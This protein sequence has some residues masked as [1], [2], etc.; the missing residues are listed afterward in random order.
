MDNEDLCKP[1]NIIQSFKIL[2]GNTRT[3][4]IF[5]PL[6][7][8]P[9]VL[10]NFYLSLYMKE[11]G[12]TD[13]QIGY[14]ISIGFISGTFFSLIA[15][16][17]T[18]KLGRKKT[19]LI[20]DAISWP[21]VVIIYLFSNSFLMFTLAVIL[22]SVGRIVGVSWNMMI[23][24]DADDNQRVAAFNLINIINIS[25]GVIIPLAGLLVSALGVVI[26][27]RIFF[28]Y[29]IISMTIMIIMRNRAYHE[30]K[31]GQQIL[32][33]QK[34]NPKKITL[35][36]ILPLK[37]LLVLKKKPNS[38]L[39][40]CVFVLF[41]IYI[42]LGTFGSLYFAPYM[43]EVLQLS[44]SS[45]SVLGG[46][47]S[48]VLFVI[49]V[50]LNPIICRFDKRINMVIGLI[51]QSVSLFL[52]VIVPPGS[53]LTAVLCIILFAIG[54]GIFRSFIDSLLAEVTEGSQRAGIYSIINTVTCISTAIIAFISGSLYV[55][56]PKLLYVA[57]ILILLLCTAILIWLMKATE[58]DTE[59]SL[60][61]TIEKDTNLSLLKAVEKDTNFSTFK[62]VE[63]DTDFSG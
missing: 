58:K 44:K 45:I 34:V 35:K 41:S 15:G 17:V 39:A 52:L 25:T 23:V 40:I 7:G 1:T 57:S 61:K 29:A 54:F 46:V 28:I 21:C 55:Y 60:M 19:T 6:W 10:F 27:E 12:V 20:F 2:K 32:D 14:L 38:I 5:E 62:V 37:T 49:F 16:T 47:Y 3:S 36:N 18:D 48:A 63:K 9:F 50:F 59:S 30:T 53:L 11:L 22:N 26:S 24:E 13:K 43:T 33:E 51:I 42:P 4:I 8:I 31:V 56:N